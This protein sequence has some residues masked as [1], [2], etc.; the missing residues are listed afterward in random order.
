MSNQILSPAI[1]VCV[2]G[3]EGSRSPIV[4][5]PDQGSIQNQTLK[6]T[7]NFQENGTPP[8]SMTVTLRFD[9]QLNNG[10]EDF[11]ITSDVVERP[12]GRWSH[13]GANHDDIARAFP[14][15]AHL[16]KWHLTSTQGPMHYLANTLYLAGDLDSMGR[17]KGQPASFS[18]GI[19]FG[20]SPMTHRISTPF[21][22]FLS[23]IPSRRER[24]ASGLP[25][26]SYVAV[27]SPD[28]RSN[29]PPRYTLNGF[30]CKWHEC[31]FGDRTQAE[32]FVQ[33]FA[34]LDHRLVTVPVLLSPGKERE[35]DAARR[36][37]VWPDAT[38]AELSRPQGELRE[39]LKARLP[40]LMAQFKSDM[41]D[42]GF[43]WPPRA[44]PAESSDLA[45]EATPAS[46]PEA[47]PAP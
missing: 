7:R 26:L 4:G 25:S 40:A 47:T 3:V 5:D 33:A 11:S 23:G 43:T 10:H 1:P 19:Q 17:E 27:H 39:V 6:F 29:F 38:D 21:F 44:D 32:E 45:P 35:L 2:L 41:L 24:L 14:E 13:G 42:L 18:H 12:S 8:F 34:T 9:D 15:F 36:A 37:A 31:P 22:E 46:R 20:D 16:T 28:R 30:A